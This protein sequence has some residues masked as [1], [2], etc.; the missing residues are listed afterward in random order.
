MTSLGVEK[1]T[2]EGVGE[3][4]KW[5]R[6]ESYGPKFVEN[7]VQGTAR[8]IL[9]NSINNLSEYDIVMHVHDEVIID[10]PISLTCDEVISLMTKNPSWCEDLCLKAD[11]YECSFYQKD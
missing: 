9:C 3:A 10:A 11:G 6:I 8:D 2:Y 5:E 7:I 4:K 1:I